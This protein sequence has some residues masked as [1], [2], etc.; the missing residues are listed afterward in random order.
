MNRMRC[1]W[2]EGG[3]TLAE[4]LVAVA[5][6]TLLMAGVFVLQ[7]EGQEAYLLGSNRVET[8]QTAR[9]ALD[10]MTRELRSARSITSIASSPDI[11]FVDQSGNTIRYCWSSSKTDCVSSGQRNYVGRTFNE[12][13]KVLTGGVQSPPGDSSDALVLTYYDKSTVLYTG[14]DQTKV[15]V[16]KISVKT[17]TEESVAA[18]SPGDQHATMES[19]I[20]L[21]AT[22]S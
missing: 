1:F 9:V 15:S 4:L 20:K 18:G 2:N 11:T 14:T 6:M 8:Q 17:K 21:R 16:I 13:Y 12:T 3:F 5:V 10:L 19:T 7:R 22:L